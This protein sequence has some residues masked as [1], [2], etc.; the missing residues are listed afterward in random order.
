MTLKDEAERESLACEFDRHRAEEGEILERYHALSDE[1]GKGP[2]GLLINH[3][4]TEEEMH[5]FLLGTLSDWLRTP[6]G[7]EESLPEDGLDRDALLRQTRMLRGHEKKTIEACR[8]LKSRLSGGERDLFDTI[9][10]A[11][12]ADS[13]KHERLLETVEKLIESAARRGGRQG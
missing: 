7:L 13:E 10:E 11:I 6:L 1:L 5:H 4:A 12:A 2:L 3:I 9:L 8:G